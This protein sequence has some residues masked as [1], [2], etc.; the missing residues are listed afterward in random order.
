MIDI[1]KLLRILG[2]KEVK[3]PKEVEERI[4]YTLKNLE[5]FKS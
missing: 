5:K 3:I 4:E 2:S 1:D